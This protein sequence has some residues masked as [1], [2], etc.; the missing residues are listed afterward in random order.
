MPS[1]NNH[2]SLSATY[3]TPGTEEKVFDHQLPTCSSNPSTNDRVAYLMA[4]RQKAAELQAQVNSFLTQKMDKDKI[5]A[6]VSTAAEEQ[7]E[8]NYGEEVVDD[9]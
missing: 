4:L 6:G 8:E 9:A 3:T 2:Q 1:E 7:E 5:D